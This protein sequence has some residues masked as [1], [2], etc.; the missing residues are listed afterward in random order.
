MQAH[1]L[2]KQLATTRGKHPAGIYHQLSQLPVERH[3]SGMQCQ[4]TTP[5]VRKADDHTAFAPFPPAL[6]AST[7]G[8]GPIVASCGRYVRFLSNYVQLI[9]IFKR[10]SFKIGYTPTLTYLTYSYSVCYI[11]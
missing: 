8:V 4:A 6:P 10:L 1:V 2:P 11:V 9:F 7:G 3:L 5:F